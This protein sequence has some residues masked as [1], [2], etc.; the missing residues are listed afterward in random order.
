[1]PISIDVQILLTVLY[2][3]TVPSE[4]LISIDV[5]HQRMFSLDD[6]DGFNEIGGK[7]Y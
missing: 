4:V 2:M 3:N 6:R 5:Q 7:S 1:M